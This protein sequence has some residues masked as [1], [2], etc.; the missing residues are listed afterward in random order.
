MRIP[1]PATSPGFRP[2][3]DLTRDA[4]ASSTLSHGLL[5]LGDRW[6]VSVLLGAYLGVRRFD[7][8]HERLGIPRSTLS[9]RL[10]KLVDL[11]LL[12]QRLYQQRPMRHGYHL[13]RAGLQLYDHVLMI[14]AWERRWG[15][16]AGV[17]PAGLRHR[18][19]GHLVTPSLAC[20]ACGDEVNMR[21]LD[22]TLQVNPMLLARVAE[23]GRSARITAPQG[24]R[25][26]VSAGAA[27]KLGMGLGLRVDR[28]SLLIVTAVLLGCHYFDQLQH[29][30][31]IAA[32]VLAR[33]L[34][35]MVEAGLLVAQPDRHDARRVV[36][37]LTPASRDLFGY[38]VCFSSWAARFHFH[39]E[40]SIAPRHRGCGQP[41]IGQA[42]CDHCRTALVPWEVEVVAN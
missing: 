24:A 6:T 11:G 30:L 39:T 34:A 8:W 17:L 32:S 25:D 23:S 14:W 16:R 12:R 19:C 41:F 27:P 10:R 1:A 5:V 4:L 35:G 15:T 2:D 28:W 40:S 36:Y 22:F 21:D 9:E 42:V 20:S 29:V 3:L 7:E 26:G 13:T 37:R 33:R 18:T 38:I 31:G